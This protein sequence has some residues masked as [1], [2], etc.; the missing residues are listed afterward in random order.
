MNVWEVNTLP[1]E[2]NGEIYYTAAEA[3][4]YLDVSRDTF[5]RNVK[6]KL[7]VYRHGALRREYFRQSDLD[8]YRGIYP[9]NDDQE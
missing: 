6:D 8:R 2:I 3:A 1:L 9:E 7:Q 5:Y 4:R